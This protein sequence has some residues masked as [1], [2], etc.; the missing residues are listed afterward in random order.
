MYKVAWLSDWAA[1]LKFLTLFG[2][3]EDIL[4]LISQCE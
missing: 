4:H 2:L 3:E 1:M